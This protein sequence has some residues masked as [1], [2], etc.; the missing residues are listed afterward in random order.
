MKS[1]IIPGLM[2]ALMLGGGLFYNHLNPPQA[3][4]YEVYYFGSESCGACKHWHKNQYPNWRKGDLSSS[5]PLHIAELRRG[6]DA[7][8]GG[9]GRH[10]EMFMKSIGY[11]N[12]VRWPSFV[13]VEEDGS[14]EKVYVGNNGWGKLLVHLE[15]N[16]ELAARAE[17]KYA[18]AR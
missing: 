17:Q 9:Y 12:R 2:A 1:L 6:Q 3:K 10:D 5:V 7:F 18:A 14:V 13:L 4:D 15:R 16:A 8:N 11:K